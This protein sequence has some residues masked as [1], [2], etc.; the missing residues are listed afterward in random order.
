MYPVNVQILVCV[1]M[2]K[3][4]Q[5]KSSKGRNPHL[6]SNNDVIKHLISKIFSYIYLSSC[7][8]LYPETVQFK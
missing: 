5:G 7:Q 2:Y 8:G 6:Q 1:S 4:L 3:D